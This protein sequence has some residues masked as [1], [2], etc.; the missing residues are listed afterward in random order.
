MGRVMDGLRIALA[1]LAGLIAYLWPRK[2]SGS[3]VD[4]P[5]VV[6]SQPIGIDPNLLR[7]VGNAG[8]LSPFAGT[9]PS[10]LTSAMPLRDPLD[11]WQPPTKADPYLPLIREQ[12]RLYGFP[13]NLLASLLY[14][15]SRFD[16]NAYNPKVGASGIAQI[17]PKW[18]PGVDPFDWEEAI[19][20]AA[21]F[22]ASLY[23]RFGSWEKALAAYNYGPTYIAK[24]GLNN[25]PKETADYYPSILSRVG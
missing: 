11:R 23:K 10:V 4:A 16:P 5:S 14:Q 9:S 3:T 12:E 17:V 8:G 6:P 21:K 22:L 25:L 15:E 13:R 2:A 20:Y 24:N 18:H 19:P 7:Q 1:G